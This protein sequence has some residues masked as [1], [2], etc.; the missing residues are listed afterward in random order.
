MKCKTRVKMI[1]LLL[2]IAIMISGCTNEKE[3]EDVPE[4]EVINMQTEPPESTAE[5][6]IVTGEKAKE[7]FE[8]QTQVILLDVRNQDEFDEYSIP[9]STLIPVNELESRLSELPDKNAT[10]IVFCR[11]GRRS[12]TAAEI[13]TS[14]GFTNVY[15][16]GSINNW[17]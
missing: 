12:A 17:E 11:A 6:V 9:D 5:A 4:G 7:I 3:P 10:I 8:T 1:L 2:I 16:M 15:D 14:N 13:L